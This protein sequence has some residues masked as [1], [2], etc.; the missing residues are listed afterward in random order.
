MIRTHPRISPRSPAIAPSPLVADPWLAANWSLLFPGLGQLYAK[1]TIRG[2]LFLI[3]QVFL[4]GVGFWSIF[5]PL[6][7]T[8]HGL[9]AFGAAIALYLIN[10]LDGFWCV[11][12]DRKDEIK[13][14]IPRKHKN[15]W[16]AV[17]ISRFIP[18]LG[19]LYLN[20]TKLGLFLLSISLMFLKL[21]QQ[22]TDFLFV[23]PLLG[24]IAS[25]HVYLSFPKRHHNTERSIVAILAGLVFFSGIIG[26]YL[27][28]ILTTRWEQFIIP[29]ESMVPTLQI[30]D[31]VLVTP[32]AQYTPER[33]DIVVFQPPKAI[34]ALD[35]HPSDFYIK[36]IV[37]LPG[38]TLTI[39]QGQVW[40][41]S[42][43]L[44]ENYTAQP[45]TYEISPIVVPAHQYFVLGD[46]R[47]NSLD[48]H[49][50]GFLPEN[51]ILGKANKI[52][53]PLHRVQSLHLP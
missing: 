5:N 6:G 41:N 30:G 53:W 49:I 10:I 28:Q 31:R 13:E 51:A 37:A 23:C 14:K 11:Y 27:P 3:T 21:S 19:H 45:P 4:L 40:I 26:N 46:N 20:Q 47:N 42:Q 33:G 22:Y 29:S 34:H 38:E 43:P 12:Q 44:K 17:F 24:A 9:M 25:Y 7:K 15:P 52:Y 50:W 16:F 2:L 18:G 1:K 32:S 39:N 48:S 36:R 8:S 35:I